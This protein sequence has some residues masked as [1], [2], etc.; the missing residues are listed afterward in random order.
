[1]QKSGKELTK[2]VLASILVA[3]SL[4]FMGGGIALAADSIAITGKSIDTSETAS[5]GSVY[6][7]VSGNKLSTDSATTQGILY[8]GVTETDAVEF[9]KADDSVNISNNTVEITSKDNTSGSA[10]GGALFVNGAGVTFND[11]L[12][13][14]NKL[15][16]NS[17]TVTVGGALAVT[18][19]VVFNVTKDAAYTGNTIQAADGYS[20][21]HDMG[22]YITT[23]GGGFMYLAPSSTVTFNVAKDTTLTIG[24]ANATDA[25]ADTIISGIRKAASNLNLNAPTIIK[26]GTGTLTINSS[27]NN[28]HG[29]FIVGEPLVS[30]TQENGESE[31]ADFSE[32]GTVNLTKD[33]N[34]A[35][36]LQVN[37]GT[38][39]LNNLTI[40]NLANKLKAN[41]VDETTDKGTATFDLIKQGFS[42]SLYVDTPSTVNAKS[43]TMNGG[44]LSGRGT[45]NVSGDLTA[46]GSNNESN[47]RPYIDLEE[48]S[49][50]S[51]GGNLTLNSGADFGSTG[52]VNVTGDFTAVGLGSPDVQETTVGLDGDSTLTVGGNFSLSA[53][54]DFSSNNSTKVSG[55][56]TI[57]NVLLGASETSKD[58]NTGKAN[59]K[60]LSI[61]G[62]ATI[63]NSDVT[64][65]GTASIDKDLTVTGSDGYVRFADLTVGGNAAINS[66][67]IF[68]TTNSLAI[69]GNLSITGEASEADDSTEIPEAQLPGVTAKG[70]TVGGNAEVTN[71]RLITSGTTKVT[72]DLSVSGSRLEA[73]DLT[74]GGKLTVDNEGEAYVGGSNL[75]LTQ[76]KTSVTG[77]S[78][79]HLSSGTLQADNLDSVIT[80]GSH[81]D[82]LDTA[83]LATKADQIFTN[84]DTNASEITTDNSLKDTIYAD[85][86]ILLEAG[87]L[88]LSDNYSYAYLT[89]IQDALSKAT[90]NADTDNSFTSQTQLLMTGDLVDTTGVPN[91]T[92][93]TN[94]IS[95]VSATSVLDA[96][97][98]DAG[99]KNVLVGADTTT[100][101]DT[102]PLAHGF[103]VATLALGNAEK[104]TVTNGQSVT[105]GGSKAD[106]AI[107][108]NADAANVTV[109]GGSSLTIGTAAV[110]AD[111][112][113]NVKAAVTAEDS[114]VTTNGKTTIAGKVALANAA[115]NANTGTAASGTSSLSGNV[116]VDGAVT[117]E[118]ATQLTTAGTTA[119]KDSVNLTSASLTAQSGTVSIAKDLA[120]SGTSSLTGTVTVGGDVTTAEG[121]ALTTDGAMALNGNVA[122]TGSSIQAK[123]GTVAIAKDLNISGTSTITGDV[124]VAG[125]IT[126]ADAKALL[127]VGTDDKA[128]T[129]TAGKINLNGGS[130]YLDPVWNGG[131][132]NDGT[133]VSIES[134]ADTNVTVGQNS[135]L[136]LGSQDTAAAEA[137]FSESGLTWGSDGILSALYVTS[138]QDLTGSSITVDSKATGAAAADTGSFTMG[139]G[140][141]LLVKGST[142]S[143]SQAAAL[144]NV[145]STNIS[146]SAKLYISGASKDTTYN[147]LSGTNVKENN[148]WYADAK[149]DTTQNV[150]TNNKLLKFVGADGNSESKF[151]VTTVSQ[152]AHDVYGDS[153]VAPDVVNAA[154]LGTGA[155]TD[156]VNNAANEDVNSSLAKQA[157]ALNSANSLSELGGVQ[158]SLYAANNLFDNAVANHLADVKDTTLD[159]DVWAHYIHTKEDV[160]GL[161]LD[162][163]TGANYDAQ[164]NGVVAGADLYHNDNTVAGLALTY[165]DGSISG[166]TDTASTKNN[167]DYY[168]LSLYGR[169][170]QG[171]TSYLGDIS[172]LHGK[173][174]LSQYNSGKEITGSV[175]SNAYSAGVRAE[176]DFNA[177][178]G[179]LTPYVG[180]RYAHL[181]YG[182]Y[183]DSLG[184]HH[185]S[186]NANLWMVPLGLRYSQTMKSG[187][188]SIKPLAEAGY[189]WTFGDRDGN[190][191]V[192][193]NGAA[194]TFGYDVSDG[195]SFYGRLGVEAEHGSMTYGIGYQYQKGSDVRSN[196]WSVALRYKF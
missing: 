83:V 62:S 69:T 61:G 148:S 172:W 147:I 33:L 187:S 112:A 169:I 35:S 37:K 149:A 160:D 32:G 133:E 90:Y 145:S 71:G 10:M 118:K 31:D 192:S 14:N 104:L 3:G 120:A 154:L 144:T 79:L 140:S 163:L 96:I 185:D 89:N 11:A 64:A 156:F 42:G 40:D 19:N 136:T 126:G 18:S 114:T 99:D 84:A 24:E 142:V 5:A 124:T 152:D 45:V 125:T 182:N 123:T 129:L 146:D 29:E 176:H 39:N 51:V 161:D 53:D 26:N 93:D 113:L 108:T 97:T 98:L 189:L 190:D 168:G 66:A 87:T 177:G 131:T 20:S 67:S 162:G 193:L 75:T 23:S 191:R 7:D 102:T 2:R 50:L 77:G 106:E 76:D 105:L 183:T 43:I 128:A 195:G 1:M 121:T 68:K 59:F 107:T 38:V 153:L 25:N 92:L 151:S 119:F 36:S 132:Q 110:T 72:G 47:N 78:W 179:T 164:Y 85:N 186:D 8:V 54:A 135:T 138:S 159:K 117:T 73:N 167:A 165:M 57:E 143:G 70:L 48:T 116:T 173:N 141:L 137:L 9:T 101:Q 52:T 95:K 88:S 4:D 34:L 91:N 16:N 157:N 41:G 94:Q 134:L 56:F 17:K 150:F 81:L 184:I 13:Q 115:L 15:I 127:N 44:D 166:N 155:A 86:H 175:S 178:A 100:E 55:D 28:Y 139:A 171:E 74:L 194:N 30:G 65:S 188:W 82:L 109:E 170:R 46:S 130:L 12:F 196:L 22:D 180:I 80:T 49:K 6:S 174:D 21:F 103:N 122:L 60:D 63:T 58:D 158:H 181:D 27:L 111:H